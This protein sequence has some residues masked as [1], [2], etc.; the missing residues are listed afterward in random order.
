MYNQT[1]SINPQD[2][3]HYY[4]LDPTSDKPPLV[5][6]HGFGDS[7][8]CWGPVAAQLGDK[9]NVIMPSARGHGQSTRFRP[10][11]QVNL[12]QDVAQFL[13]ALNVPPA[14]LMGHSMG[15]LM[16][17]LT[18]AN[19]PNLVRAIIL[20]DPP[21]FSHAAM[22]KF[23]DEASK[24]T[25]PTPIDQNEFYL[26]L[27]DLQA[28]PLPEVEAQVR[29]EHPAWQEGEFAPWAMSKHEFDLNFFTYH[30]E[31]SWQPWPE[32]LPKLRCPGLLLW[33]EV[34]LGGLVTAE[35]VAEVL[36]VWPQGQ[37]VQIPRV[38]HNIRRDNFADFSTAVAAYLTTLEN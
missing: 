1:I 5:L 6:L 35:A 31:W 21:W 36:A 23:A 3:I 19:Y 9:Y 26:W 16:A 33:G 2:H 12:A 17:A 15:A 4:Q 13:T 18:A 27:R 8:A 14:I 38:G 37:A 22:A 25:E 28:L 24:Q 30:P 7:G 29:A 10:N 34:A 32:Y 20:S 11:E